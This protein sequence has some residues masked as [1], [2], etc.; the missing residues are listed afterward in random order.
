ML[1]MAAINAARFDPGLKDYYE[2][3]VE[4]GKHKMSVLNA[5]R[6]KIIH[7]VFA[8]VRDNRIYSHVAI[9]YA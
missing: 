2:R 1:Q 9:S 6:N 3:K 5:I 4:S 8:C 7:R